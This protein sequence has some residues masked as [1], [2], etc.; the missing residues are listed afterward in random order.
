MTFSSPGRVLAVLAFISAGSSV[1]SDSRTVAP[2]VHLSV[3][4]A[5]FQE[6]VTP[7]QGV[8]PGFTAVWGGFVDVGAGVG[9]PIAATLDLELGVAG[10]LVA[11]ADVERTAFELVPTA[12]VRMFYG[13][14][15]WLKLHAGAG[16]IVVPLWAEA[17]P[18]WGFAVTAAAQWG[19][20]TLSRGLSLH[21]ELAVTYSRLRD[22]IGQS[23][24]VVPRL[25]IG[26][27]F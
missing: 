23:E 13:D 2:R 10:T 7:I 9:M 21:L 5:T 14:G 11:F 27:S 16:G 24:L 26:V 19:L 18:R 25:G 20:G 1:A 12:G 3:G 22:R 15:R 6:T 17:S 4:P 8:V